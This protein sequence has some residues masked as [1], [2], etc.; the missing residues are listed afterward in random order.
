MTRFNISLEGGIALVLFALERAMGGE[1]YVSKLASYNLT[2]V[3]TAIA[4]DC[5]QRIVGIR[6][7][8]KL[9]EE[10]ITQ[11]DSFNTIELDDHYIICPT[12]LNFQ[13]IS[14]ENYV[15]HYKSE[16][17]KMVPVGF[18]YNSGENTDWLSISDIQDIVIEHVD[19]NFKVAETLQAA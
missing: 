1:I 18:S 4:P 2:D 5:E 17:A 8:E 7:G 11:S 13:G 19:P 14:T 16:N 15:E 9:H 3:A 6:P 10:M 12:N